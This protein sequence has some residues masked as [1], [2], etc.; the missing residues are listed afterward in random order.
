MRGMRIRNQFLIAMLISTLGYIVLLQGFTYI[1]SSGIIKDKL[2]TLS[3]ENLAQVSSRLDTII[4]DM[5]IA[6]NAIALN[7]DILEVLIDDDLSTFERM[8]KLQPSI[9]NIDAANLYP[10]TVEITLMD[11]YGNIFSTGSNMNHNYQDMIKE[12]WYRQAEVSKG[13][14]QWIGP[15]QTY[16][17]PYTDADGFTMV[18]LIRKDY[19]QPCGVLLLHMYNEKKVKNLLSYNNKLAGTNRY[20]LNNKGGVILSSH[21][22]Q[23]P[24]DVEGAWREGQLNQDTDQITQDGESFFISTYPIDKTDWLLVQSIPYETLMGESITY[25]NFS[26]SI[27]LLFV[28]LVVLIAFFLSGRLTKSHRQLSQLMASV[29]QG[30]FS[31][32]SEVSGSYEIDTLS[33]SFNTMTDRINELIVDIKTESEMRQKV[34]LEA[35]QAQINPHFLMNTLNGIKWLCIIENAKTA[36][37]MLRDL[38]VILEGAMGK[39]DEFISIEEEIKCLESYIRLQ[40]MRYGHI[41]KVDFSIEE[42][43]YPL[44]I[45]VLLL[46]PIVENCILHAFEDLE[47]EGHIRIAIKRENEFVIIVIEDDGTG[48]NTRN[49]AKGGEGHKKGYSSIGIENVKERI[50]LYYGSSCGLH[51]ES[52]IGEGTVVTITI[53]EIINEHFA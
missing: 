23:E 24:F 10:Y 4:E 21:E 13:F 50:Q 5:I 22:N 52:N 8:K 42:S 33:H 32:R 31:V 16:F 15:T 29:E 14:F 49:S 18:R 48:F 44:K 45:P 41:F 34:K 38:G 47:E 39:Y 1:Y 27:N 28:L 51:I 2:I 3:N 12:E 37:K 17:G 25:R 26:I 40:R 11:F 6:S 30:D 43:C 20:I 36:E 35:L 53:K 7:E 19:I 9:D 46:Q